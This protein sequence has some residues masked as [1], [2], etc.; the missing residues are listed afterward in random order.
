VTVDV[1]P[2]R[3][4]PDE[5]PARRPPQPPAARPEPAPTR[6]ERRQATAPAPAAPGHERAPDVHVSIGRIEVRAPAEPPRA[7][8]AAPAAPALSLRDYLRSRDRAADGR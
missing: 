1:R 5:T 2:A 8:R 3:R 7:P 4:A 6:A